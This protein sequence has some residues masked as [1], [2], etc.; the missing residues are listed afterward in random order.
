MMGIK[1]VNNSR[2]TLFEGNTCLWDI[3]KQRR[4]ISERIIYN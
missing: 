2:M 3:R 4:I 1:V